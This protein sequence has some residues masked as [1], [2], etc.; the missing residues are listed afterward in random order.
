MAQ[1]CFEKYI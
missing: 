1:G